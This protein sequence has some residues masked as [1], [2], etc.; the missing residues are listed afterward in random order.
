ML[1]SGIFPVLVQYLLGECV[2]FPCGVSVIELCK[3]TCNMRVCVC[4]H[5]HVCVCVCVCMCVCVC[6]CVHVFMCVCACVCV[7]C[8]GVGLIDYLL[9]Y[10]NLQGY[11]MWDICHKQC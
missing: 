3:C 8:V 5:V 2:K 9:Y 4:V 6:V 1:A 7:W 10:N 11:C